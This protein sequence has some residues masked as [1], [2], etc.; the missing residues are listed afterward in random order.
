MI[1]RGG[2]VYYN[3]IGVIIPPSLTSMGGGGRIS[4]PSG[5]S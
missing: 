1:Y 3:V 5:L 2:E 4:L